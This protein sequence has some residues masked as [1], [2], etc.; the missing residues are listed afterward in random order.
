MARRVAILM[1]AAGA[2][3]GSTAGAASARSGKQAARSH[4][5]TF[6]GRCHFSGVVQFLPPLTS[7]PQPVSDVADAAGACSGTLTDQRGRAWTL[8]EQ[9]VRYVATDRGEAVSCAGGHSTGAGYLRFAQGRLHF[10]LDELRASGAASLTLT[11]AAG[12]GAQGEAHVSQTED[13]L[14]IAAACAGP[15]LAQARVDIDQVTTPA[16]SG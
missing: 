7:S 10:G 15:G 6:S 13:P 14:A 1:L 3:V 4:P 9:P 12:G 8:D 2:I 11:G 16:L 5:L